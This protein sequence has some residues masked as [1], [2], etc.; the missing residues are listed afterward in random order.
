VTDKPKCQAKIWHQFYHYGCGRT[1]TVDG[2][3]CK[4]HDPERI[5]KRNAEREAEWRAE[6]AA[7][8]EAHRQERVRSEY[9]GHFTVALR[10]IADGHTD[11]RQ[12]AKDILLSYE[13]EIA[14]KV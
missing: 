11:P 10:S 13:T 4:Q 9:M 5:K 7:R 1:A 14:E 6:F 3:W 2:K 12:L 8:D